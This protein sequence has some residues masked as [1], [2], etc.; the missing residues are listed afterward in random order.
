[1]VIQKTLEEEE[2]ENID[3]LPEP[4]IVLEL[5]EGKV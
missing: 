5:E 2:E 4:S 1:M 3:N